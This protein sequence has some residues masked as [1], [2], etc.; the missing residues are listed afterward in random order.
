MPRLVV[1][2][3]HIW[4]GP[5]AAIGTL[6]RPQ[7]SVRPA[8]AATLRSYAQQS[9]PSSKP[10]PTLRPLDSVII[11][12]GTVKDVQPDGLINYINPV[13][14]EKVTKDTF[15][16]VL[17]TP[18]FAPW[19]LNDEFFLAKAIRRAYSKAFTGAAEGLTIQALAAVVD[20]LPAG[21]AISSGDTMDSVVSSRS[22]E[23]PVGDTGYEGIAFVT[24]PATASIQTTSPKSPD[25]GAID[26]VLS[27]E[28]AG[29]S[30][31]HNTWRLPLANTVFQTGTPT[32]MHLSKWSL[33]RAAR[34]LEL[35]EKTYISHHGVDI[36]AADKTA[37][38]PISA[39]SIPLLPLTLPRQ[40]EGCM[41]NIIRSVLNQN[42]ESV[43]ASSELE[44]VVPQF[45]KSR[46]EPPQPTTAWALV[47]P[48]SLRVKIVTET[49]KLLTKRIGRKE[50]GLDLSDELWERLWRSDPTAW[51]KLVS[52]ALGE[53]ARLHRVLSGGGGWGKKAGLLSLD[54]VP[55]SEEVPIRMEDATSGFDGPGDFS[56]ALTPVV[57]DGDAIQFFVSP[58]PIKTADIP[59]H[60]ELE[61]L[62]STPKGNTWGWEL[63]TI[64]SSVDSIPGDSWQHV[65]SAS[66]YAAVFR[67]SFG[68]LTEGGMTL[69]RRLS[70][71][72][73]EPLST[74]ATTTIDV[75]Y[76]RVWTAKVLSKQGAAEDVVNQDLAVQV[77][78]HCYETI[79]IERSGY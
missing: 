36:T 58:T 66:K 52:N 15:C 51:N 54:P 2:Q 28:R 12:P 78:K 14:P 73:G 79:V 20:K 10:F 41:G 71:A 35:E 19:I 56:T 62:K 69:T 5:R 6:R 32:T 67:H 3:W 59:E 72:P 49:M 76:S 68:A 1:R 55:V 9:T 65:S 24:L 33:S 22:L 75:P 37:G 64:P 47:L 11:I 8:I 39:L 26:F 7:R 17:V 63:G 45:F 18:S 27:G 74:L 4:R 44:T 29:Q 30:T 46:G 21:R 61:K 77:P 25:K 23:P 31:S 53:G 16:V 38:Q 60:D 40:V 43:T 57:Q 70:V 13:P 42:E 34:S 50:K 48:R